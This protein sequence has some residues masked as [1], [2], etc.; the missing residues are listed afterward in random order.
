MKG[1]GAHLQT[2][3]TDSPAPVFLSLPLLH[4][5]H[6]GSTTIV[7][8]WVEESRRNWTVTNLSV[9]AHLKAP[10]PGNATYLMWNVHTCL[11]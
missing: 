2:R 9:S 5:S 1:S 7:E 10:T 6:C 3:Y 11:R 4:L 8:K